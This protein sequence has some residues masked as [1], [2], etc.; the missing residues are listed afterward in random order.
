MKN[1]K[2]FLGEMARNIGNFTPPIEFYPEIRKKYYQDSHEEPIHKDMTDDIKVHKIVSSIDGKPA[3]SYYTNNNKTKETLHKSVV[4]RHNPNKNLPFFHEENRI[5]ER[6][7]NTKDL[8]KGYA[9]DFAYEHFKNSKFPLRSSDTQ[10]KHGNSMWK[11]LTKRALDDN[12]HVY[13]HDGE[14]LNKTNYG[15]LES[16][17][18]SYFDSSDTHENKHMILSKTKLG[19]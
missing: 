2:S 10:T 11:K 18:N 19:D 13:F 16:H 3:I 6:V 9:T 15:N 8:P 1:F 17:L 7:K 12:H 4:V 5:I 14:K